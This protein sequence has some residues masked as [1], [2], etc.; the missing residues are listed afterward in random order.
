MGGFLKISEC[1]LVFL[2]LEQ[3]EPEVVKNLRRF[4]G[5]E[6]SYVFVG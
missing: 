1:L 2:V 4:L 5:V 3:G 6:V